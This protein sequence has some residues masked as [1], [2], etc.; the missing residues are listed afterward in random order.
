MP[1]RRLQPRALVLSP[2]SVDPVSWFAGP[3][4][5]VTFAVA[6][7]VIGTGFV[8]WT[9]PQ[10]TNP[11]VQFAA[12]LCFVFACLA[13][14]R[15]AKPR[16]QPF[17]IR[18]TVLPTVL[19]WA[20]VIVSALGVDR[21]HADVGQWWAPL[22][23]AVVLA[24]LAPFSSAALLMGVGLLSTAACA[25]I[26]VLTFGQQS[27]GGWPILTTVIIAGM[28]PLQGTAAAAMFSGVIVDRVLRWSALPI[29]GRLST[30]QAL[31]FSLWNADRDELKLLGDRVLPFITKVA[32]NGF[33]TLRDRTVAAELAREIRDELLKT[34]DRSWLEPL[35]SDHRL[36]VVD[37]EN[38]AVRL[39]L[40]QRGAVRSMLEAV[41]NSS[42]LV[43]GSLSME[44]REA[45]DH[46]VAAGL[47]MRL[48]LPE[49]KRLMLLAPHYL[50]LQA[51]VDDL[52]WEDR[53]QLSMRFR[54]PPPE[55]NRD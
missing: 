24:A 29:R 2:Q 6:M 31:D 1:H 47:S 13:V 54:I 32:D 33:V 44:L 49:G 48:E 4:L 15:P 12:V 50:T 27:A 9:L 14:H 52:V 37:P 51:A 5:P 8:L 7:G 43:P 17:R 10:F 38:L 3:F 46:G 19:A 23:I 42:A 30:D 25:V 39:T 28:V 35:A 55:R 36:K 53:D 18:H 22:G 21:P 34:A 45:E 11:F 40:A 41:L 20:G 16:L 26:G